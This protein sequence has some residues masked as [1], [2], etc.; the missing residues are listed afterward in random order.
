M[1][2]SGVHLASVAD[3]VLGI[4]L[5]ERHEPQMIDVTACANAAL[6]VDH[7]AL[8]NRADFTLPSEPM[9]SYHFS[10]S[11][12]HAISTIVPRA[13]KNVARSRQR[14]DRARLLVTNKSWR[15][16]GRASHIG[17]LQSVNETV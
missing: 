15:R 6:M 5:A 3:Y 1:R 13:A 9:D 14:R 16:A 12:N 4:V 7:H 8:R 2:F 17:F 11:S 10:K